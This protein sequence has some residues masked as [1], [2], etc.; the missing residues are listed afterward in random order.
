MAM[1]TM[2]MWR[3]RPADVLMTAGAMTGMRSSGGFPPQQLV[4]FV[5]GVLLELGEGVQTC[6]PRNEYCL[7]NDATPQLLYIS[8]TG[9]YM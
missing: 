3:S 2:L 6:R 7:N 5:L 1:I 8:G 9:L 4:V